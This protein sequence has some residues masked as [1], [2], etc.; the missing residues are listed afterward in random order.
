M[1]EGAARHGRSR[2]AGLV[3]LAAAVLLVLQSIASFGGAA[4]AHGGHWPGVT[5]AGADCGS[6]PSDRSHGPDRGG[7]ALCIICAARD[8][9]QS[10][11]FD[12]P[13]RGDEARPAPRA[14]RLGAPRFDDRAD[15][16]APPK[17]S[18]AARAPP[19]S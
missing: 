8:C 19:L 14:R 9:A 12:M 7:C 18:G 10:F 11:L 17:G 4:Q 15:L 13:S 1:S 3:A 6:V 16:P 2:A 5:A